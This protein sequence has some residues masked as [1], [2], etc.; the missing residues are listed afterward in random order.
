MEGSS[1]GEGEGSAAKTLGV[2]EVSGGGEEDGVDGGSVGVGVDPVT[3]GGCSF[4]EPPD[5]SVGID[6]GSEVVVLC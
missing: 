2:E 4:G 1:E 6:A 3:G 5:G